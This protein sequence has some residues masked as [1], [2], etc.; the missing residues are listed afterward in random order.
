MRLSGVS[1][2]SINHHKPHESAG[3]DHSSSSPKQT[4]FFMPIIHC[5]IYVMSMFD[6][7]YVPQ[8]RPLRKK[9]AKQRFI[10]KWVVYVSDFFYKW[11]LFTF[12]IEKVN[13]LSAVIV[14]ISEPNSHSFSLI[15]FNSNATLLQ[16]ITILQPSVSEVINQIW[17]NW[18]CY[19]ETH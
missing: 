11:S 13:E 6:S 9:T 18:W 15:N 17:R 7:V 3:W 2:L 14:F 16:N 4:W 1:F 8:G 5:E 19:T 10:E 12:K